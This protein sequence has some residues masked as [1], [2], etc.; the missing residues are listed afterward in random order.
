MTTRSLARAVIAPVAIV[1]S[2]LLYCWPLVRYGY[3]A[4]TDDARWH[5]VYA[6]QFLRELSG[7]VIYPRWLSGMDDGLGSPTFY[8][9]PPLSY[10][11]T[12]LLASVTG[13]RNGL[14]GHVIDIG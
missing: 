11:L 5:V 6:E 4:D 7:G 2:G 9:Y 13:D 12:S 10:Y 1:V 14:V 8:F 3:P